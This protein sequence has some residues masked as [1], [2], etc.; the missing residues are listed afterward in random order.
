LLPR[1]CVSVLPLFFKGQAST[2]Q[3]SGLNYGNLDI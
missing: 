1:V 3:G 2:M